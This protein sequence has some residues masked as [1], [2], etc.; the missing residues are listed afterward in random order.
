MWKYLFQIF[1]IFLALVLLIIIVIGKSIGKV[2]LCMIM[3]LC[4]LV[5][6]DN[7]FRTGNFANIMYSIK[8]NKL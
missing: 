2:E 1:N 4:L 3:Y 8:R 6:I 7:L 5:A